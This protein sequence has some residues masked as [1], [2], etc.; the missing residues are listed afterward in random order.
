MILHNDDVYLSQALEYMYLVAEKCHADVVHS[1]T[2]FVT[3][4]DGIIQKGTNLK[5]VHNKRPSFLYANSQVN[6]I[7]LVSD[8]PVVRFNEWNDG[9]IFIDAQYNIFNR[10][11]FMK[12]NLNFEVFNGWFG[13]NRILA[14]KWIMKAK[15]LVKTI[16]PFYIHRSSRDSQTQLKFT[17]EHVA[18][19]ITALIELS[20]HLDEY[21]AT[22][23]FFRDNKKFQYLA[24]SHL[25]SV[26]D[27]F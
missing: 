27:G 14:L 2:R 21:F 11:F 24:R 7:L 8:N 25:F 15:V 20:R 10:D 18:K 1:Q 9:G 23:K 5:F 17:S 19:F 4:E 6:K 13:D 12:N 22:E 3:D 16:E 26:L